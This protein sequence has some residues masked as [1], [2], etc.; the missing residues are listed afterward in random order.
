MLL[1]NHPDLDYKKACFDAYNRW[2]QTYVSHDPERLIGMGQTCIR[3]VKEGIEDL[4]RIKAMGFRGVMMP[5]NPGEKDYDDPA[6]DPF[7]EAAVA[8]RAAARLP[9]P[10]VERRQHHDQAARA[11]D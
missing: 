8:L 4:E 2:L 10:D 7:W 6:F 1:C 9:H 11:Q 5:G 3:T